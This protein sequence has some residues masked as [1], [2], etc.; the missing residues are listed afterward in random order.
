VLLARSLSAEAFGLYAIVCFV[1]GAVTLCSDFGMHHCLIRWPGQI[2]QEIIDTVFTLRVILTVSLSL[3]VLFVVAPL[4]CVWYGTADL[5]WLLASVL[6]GAAA[7]SMFRVSHSLLEREMEYPKLA[8]VELASLIA[9][10]IPAAVMAYV[11]AGVYSLVIGE[12]FRGLATSLAFVARPF[13]AGLRVDRR[14]A[15]AILRFGVSYQAMM[16]TWMLGTGVNP[17]VVARMVGLKAAGII[18][19]AEA[20]TGH[21]MMFK[22]IA[23]R[24]SYSALAKFQGDRDAVVAAVRLGRLWQCVVGVMPLFA[25]TALGFWLVPL[26][27]GSDWRDVA[28]ILPLL[29]LAA[30]ANS[31]F[32]LQSPALITIGRNWAV[33]RFHTVYVLAIWGIAPV[34]VYYLGY[35]GLPVAMLIV[36]PVYGVLQRSFTKHFGPLAHRELIGAL[37]V[38]W[39][40]TVIAWG[41]AD[42]ATAT[43]IFVG[44]HLVLIASRR[45]LREAIT[46]LTTLGGATIGVR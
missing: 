5:Y 32:A 21:L 31:L 30:A 41:M 14:A 29:C 39:A 37:L 34:C 4:A 16:F 23:D 20:I 9:F 44:G 11:G 18:R 43:G 3:L 35:M 42:F 38:S 22:G 15:K 45:T 12:V 25:F 6:V 26:I 1:L 10:Y 40:I 46:S 17:I 8:V 13:H 27:Y 24:I 33:A 19:V 7:S 2:G 28:N 36:T